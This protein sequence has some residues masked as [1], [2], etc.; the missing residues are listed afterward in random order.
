MARPSPYPPELRERAV[1]M[2]AEIRPNY[3]T[4]WAAMKAVAAKLGIGAA[5]TVRTWVRK[6]EVDAGQRPGVTSAGAAEIKRLRA[7]NAELRRANEILKAAS[8]FFAA[9]LDRPSK[10]S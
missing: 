5:E 8:A 4:E 7:E 6:T 2:V 3:A 9:E 1:R 10:R